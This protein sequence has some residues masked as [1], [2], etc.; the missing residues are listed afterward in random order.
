MAHFA[1]LGNTNLVLRVIVVDNSD[2]VDENGNES[3]QVGIAYCKSLFGEDTV[4]VQTSYNSNF[5]KN[6]AHVGGT[7]DQDN[8]AFIAEKP[9][10]SWILDTDTFQW[11]SPIGPPPDEEDDPLGNA[12][13]WDEENQQ[14]VR[15]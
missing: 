5:R 11:Q 9:Y 12:Y 8:D 15:V 10:P 2:C 3:E 13:R 14:W 1:E 7:Y 4:W 6:Y